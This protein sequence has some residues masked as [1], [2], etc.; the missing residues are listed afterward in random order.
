M[1]LLNF[2]NLR[3][4]DLGG[5]RINHEN[6]DL[7]SSV[8]ILKLDSCKLSTTPSEFPSLLKEL[9]LLGNP[10]GSFEHTKFPSLT[11]LDISFCGSKDKGTIFSMS[12]VELHSTLVTLRASGNTVQDWSFTR[13]PHGV[14]EWAFRTTEYAHTILFPSKLESLEVEF[15][16]P[17]TARY[18][19]L[20]LPQ[21]LVKLKLENGIADRFIRNLPGLHSFTILNLKGLLRS[22]KR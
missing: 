4:L 15:L 14:K 1:R 2:P 9:N 17:S 22:L 5:N 7:P 21:T 6:F 12:S 10:I 19:G 16:E 11:I 20:H 13:L 3:F 18:S 8:E